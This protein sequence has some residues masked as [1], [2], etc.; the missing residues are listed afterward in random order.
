MAVAILF[1]HI[2]GLRKP[3]VVQRDTKDE[4]EPDV[5]V[6]ERVVK[7]SS[8]SEDVVDRDGGALPNELHYP[9]F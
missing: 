1:R 6:T 8:E 7:S 9:G 5:R 4:R 2:R 3:E